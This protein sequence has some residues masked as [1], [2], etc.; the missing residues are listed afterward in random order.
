MGRAG[1]PSETE[2]SFFF[3]FG[4]SVRENG[5]HKFDLSANG[6][7]VVA[8]GGA[9]V[10]ESPVIFIR[11]HENF[12]GPRRGLVGSGALS[13]LPSSRSGGSNSRSL[14]RFLSS[15]PS[16]RSAPIFLF[17][18]LFATFSSPDPPALRREQLYHSLEMAN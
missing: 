14:E 9:G 2:D 11:V 18:T 13:R 4:L 5:V 1:I 16:S 10:R 8:S 6:S 12:K 17:A 15:R 7:P 3:F